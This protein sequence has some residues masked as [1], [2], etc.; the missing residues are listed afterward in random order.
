MKTKKIHQKKEGIGTGLD[1]AEQLLR[2]QAELDNY[3]KRVEQEKL[4]LI[5]YANTN[6]IS[7][8]LPVLDNF[9]RAATHAPQTTDATISNW[10][11]GIKAVEKQLEDALKQA[12]LDVI[13]TQVGDM[14]DH[15]IHDA[16][17]HDEDRAPENTIIRIV[18]SGYSLNDRVLRPVKVTVSAGMHA[19]KV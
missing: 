19:P 11:I 5:K 7:D 2:A 14:F 10:I 12:G 13:P 3:R 18:E 16:I 1:D 4:S 17:S 8:I 6:L 9:K 15:N